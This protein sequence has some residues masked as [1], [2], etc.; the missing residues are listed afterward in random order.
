MA[1]TTCILHHHAFTTISRSS[2]SSSQRPRPSIKP[3]RLVCRAQNKSLSNGNGD[4]DQAQGGVS[5]RLVLENL[6][7][8]S[9]AVGSALAA[10]VS[11]ACGTESGS[12][13][14]KDF[15]LYPP[16]K[17]SWPELVGEKGKV[18]VK[19]IEKENPNV[20]AILLSENSPAI[21]NFVPTRVRVVVN[22]KGV[23][24]QVPKA[25]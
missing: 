13:D 19:I 15:S 23:V 5:R 8:A 20:Q 24:T 2:S 12:T 25:G 6:I 7:V 16:G 11:P 10:F 17:L 21:L 1:S 3:S 22:E 4:G 9:A 18:A 14:D